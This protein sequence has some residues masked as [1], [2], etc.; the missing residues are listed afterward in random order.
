MV[1]SLASPMTALWK[2]FC[3]CAVVYALSVPALAPLRP[4]AVDTPMSR[5]YAAVNAAVLDQRLTFDAI[6][7]PLR[8]SPDFARQRFVAMMKK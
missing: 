3:L 1:L 6:T 7:D 2:T 4:E 8:R 5:Y